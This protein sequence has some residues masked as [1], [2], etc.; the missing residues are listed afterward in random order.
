VKKHGFKLFAL[1]ALLALVVSTFSTQATQAQ[2]NSRTFPETGKTVSGTFLTYWDAHGGLAQQGYPI[3]DPMSEQSTVDGKTYTVQ[4]FERA[5]FEEHPEFAGTPNEVLLSLLGVFLYNQKYPSGASGQTPNAEANARKFTETGHTVGGKFLDYWNTHGG[6]AQQ[7]YPIS[8]EFNEVSALDGKTYKVQYFERAVFEEHPEFAGTPNEVLLSQLGTFRLRDKQTP[9]TAT[10]APS[11]PTS[12]PAPAQPTNTPAP[13]ATT[14]A[15]C[16]QGVPDPRSATVTPKCGPIG[17]LFNITATGFT[18][19][20]QISFWLTL[21]NGSVL[22]TPS[23]LDIG[24][25]SGS[26]RDEF[27]SS[28]LDTPGL[29]AS[30]IWAITYE[31]AQSRHQSIVWFK[32]TPKGGAGATATPVTAQSCDT[33]GN[34]DGESTPSGGKPGDTLSFVARGFTPGEDVSYWF[35]L[36]DQSVFGTAQPLSGGVHSDGTIGPLHFTILQSDVQA[37]VGRWAITFEGASSHHTSVIYFCIH[38]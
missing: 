33:S 20:E 1:V 2:G 17:T 16:D 36:P 15:S 14:V 5:V 7:G 34:R 37:G 13:V 3:S 12:T 8:D 29:D 24:S 23:P 11:A 10:R 22:G 38:P 26:I 28:L 32:I 31:G 6:L 9:A 30:G 4:Y 18:P 27:D 35:T 25:H 19:N 21:P